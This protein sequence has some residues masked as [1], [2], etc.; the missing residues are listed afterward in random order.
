MLSLSLRFRFSRK[1]R[2]SSLVLCAR[3]KDN[4]RRLELQIGDSPRRGFVLQCITSETQGWETCKDLNLGFFN[5][6]KGPTPFPPSMDDA[7]LFLQYN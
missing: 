2:R 6:F 5:P 3:S 7:N 1:C 4:G